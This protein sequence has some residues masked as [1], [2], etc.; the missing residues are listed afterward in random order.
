MFGFFRKK[1]QQE[2]KN[3]VT[4]YKEDFNDVT[5][6]AEYFYKETGITFQQQMSILKSKVSSFCR[7]RKI[8]SFEELLQKMKNDIV[9]K[10]ELINA[11]TT[12]ETFF[13]R[14][15]KQIQELV[16]LVKE[17]NS[18]SMK[19]L[20]APC[21]TGEE[22]FSIAIALLEADVSPSSFH[23]FGI[24]INAEAIQKAKKAV[25]R[26]RNIRNLSSEILHKYFIVKHEKYYL[27]ENIKLLVS[28]EVA[29]IFDDSF[30]NLGKFDFVFSRNM[31]IYFDKETKQRAKSILQNMRKNEKHDVFFG[32]A[33]LF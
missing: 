6:V 5:P 14:E 2:E 13:Y 30:K 17:Q 28:F 4:P 33:D 31:L 15:V 9:L 8:S 23:I 11:L 12:N 3:P 29:N 24:D 25:Y 19:I 32:H 16:K 27:K 21:A 1:V 7:Q 10:Q 22:P 18:N 20:C 26:E